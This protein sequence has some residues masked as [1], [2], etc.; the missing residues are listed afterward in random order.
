MQVIRVDK[1]VVSLTGLCSPAVWPGSW[2]V[3]VHGPGAGDP[4]Y[5]KPVLLSM[6][7][8]SLDFPRDRP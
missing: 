1:L 5:T 8:L 4:C 3:L 7:Y 6:I 2:M